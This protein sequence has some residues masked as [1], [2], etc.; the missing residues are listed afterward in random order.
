MPWP[1]TAR[2]SVPAR[3][4]QHE[5]ASLTTGFAFNLLRE[6][7]A[8]GIPENIFL[9]PAS[10]QLCLSLLYDGAREETRRGIAQALGISALSEA[11]VR[12]AFVQ[13]KSTLQSSDAGVQL[14][15][16]TSLWYQQGITLDAAYIAHAR[17]MYDAEVNVLDF[18][19]PDAASRI[20]AWVTRKTAGKITKLATGFDPLTFL[21]ALNAIYFKGFWAAP[22]LRFLTKD[23]P[24]FTASGEKMLPAMRQR[25]TFPY[26]EQ[27][28]FQAVSLPYVDGNTAML[29]VLPARNSS[30]GWLHQTLDAATW[31][32]WMKKLDDLKGFLQLPRIKIDYT[33][34]LRAALTSLGMGRAF[35]R[36]SA[37]FDGIKNDPPRLWVDQILHRAVAEV[38][39]EGTEAAAATMS[40]Y[41][42]ASARPEPP[43]RSFQMIVDRPFLFVIYE[44]RAGN[45]LFIGSVADPG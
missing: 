24:F 27:D 43:Q 16:A 42:G 7:S 20:N 33:S 23:R 13:L 25:G 40:D 41:Y 35:D 14:L 1:F 4:L 39:E 11:D 28:E 34:P 31:A 45:I 32:A 30:L 17:E 18:A 12:L 37:E 38:N 26:Y 44:Q 36:D 19:Q 8:H 9:S 5:S 15:A 29:I 2:K 10:I 21:V 3:S 22:F 6:L